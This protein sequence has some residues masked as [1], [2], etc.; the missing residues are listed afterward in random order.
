M[1]P[2]SVLDLSP[3]T[4]GGD[5]AQSFRNTPR[6]GPACRA[7]G[8]SALLAGRASRHARHRQRRHRRADRPCGGGTSSHPGRRRR[9]H[10][11][12]PCAAGDRRAVRHPGGAV[13]RPH[14]PGP[15]P[16]A[17]LRPGHRPGAAPQ[18]GVRAGPVSPGRGGAA[19]PTFAPRAAPGR[20]A[21]SPAR[22]CTCR[23]GSWAPACSAPSWRRR[24]GCPTPSPRIS[25]RR[26]CMQAIAG[27]PRRLPPLG[28][29][30]TSPT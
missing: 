16:R 8:L 1:I 13:P 10:A 21:P 9:H 20:C 29:A 11:A 14:R 15:G 26:R 3:I 24:W 23:S 19:W 2:F 6:S 4:E 12:Q 18:P 25:R 7:L 28:A 22:G 30:A 5:A 17:R 27:L